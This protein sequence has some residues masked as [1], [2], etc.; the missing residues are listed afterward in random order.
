[1]LAF[2]SFY[3]FLLIFVE[4]GL[5]MGN[6]LFYKKQ[7]KVMIMERKLTILLVEDDQKA[8]NEIKSYVD[9]TEDVRLTGI[10]DDSREALKMVQSGLPDA[11][12]LDL[13]LHLGGGNGLLFLDGL[14]NLVLPFRPYI[15]VTTNNSSVI[16][17]EQ[18]R[19]MG[20]DFILAKYESE[21]SAQYVIEF[22][23]MMKATIFAAAS[24]STGNADI[25]SEDQRNHRLI[26]RI[27][28]ELDLIGIS[29]KAIG[30][31]YL[32]DAILETYHDPAPNLCRRLSEKYHKS[33]V[34][35]ERAIQNAINRAWRIS[36]PEDLLTHYTARIRSDKG[37]PTMMEFVHYYV[38]M[39]KL[40]DVG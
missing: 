22:L 15:L 33:D 21:Y 32:T 36:D 35:I 25:E 3:W 4:N 10:T 29:P 2:V 16:T 28:R 12:I 38:K 7:Q 24:S 6:A 18:A 9:S 23:R 31:Q 30:Y 26:Q 5:I 40:E 37:V 39:L 17:L 19:H 14:K 20:A 11:V 8:C 13:E 1:M 34:S 27:Q